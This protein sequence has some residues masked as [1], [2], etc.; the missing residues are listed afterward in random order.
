LYVN[1]PLDRRTLYNKSSNHQV[2]NRIKSIQKISNAIWQEEKN[3]WIM[4]PKI[5]IESINFLPNGLLYSLL[6]KWNCRK[7]A[8][9]ISKSIEMLGFKDPILFVDNDFFNAQY[10]REYL[11]V[12]IFVYYIRD[13]LLS[14]PYFKRH[15]LFAEPNLIK[16]A[17][18]VAA[19]SVYLAQYASRYNTRVADIGQGC[20]IDSYLGI[21]DEL[22][23]DFVGIP[24]PIVGYTGSLTST[25]LDIELLVYLADKQ[26]NWSFVFVGPEDIIFLKSTLHNYPNVYFLG[27][28]NPIELPSFVH[29]FDVCINPQILNEM[30][31]G[32]YPRKVDEYLAAGKPVVAT[33]T[34]AMEIFANETYLCDGWEDY[35]NNIRNAL[36]EKDKSARALRRVALAKSHT[37]E[38]SVLKLY[39]LLQF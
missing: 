4:N 19:N 12:N 28:K 35:I 39:K 26:P 2:Q 8:M 20:D 5:V 17:D 31:I 25:R 22:P 11:D 37:W 29:G 3:L 23:N 7:L 15:G 34:Q 32:N 18:Y 30:T 21:P 9:E 33:R 27:S 14:Q 6:N 13:F 1:R 16:K 10:L 36:E 24:R 38:M